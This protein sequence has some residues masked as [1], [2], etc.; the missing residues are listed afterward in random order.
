MKQQDD[1]AAI[2]YVLS[3]IAGDLTDEEIE[4]SARLMED[5]AIRGYISEQFA[6]WIIDDTGISINGVVL[7]KEKDPTDAR[8][9]E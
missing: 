4:N 7:G 3:P 5:D 1:R 2:R 8:R 9:R 6:G